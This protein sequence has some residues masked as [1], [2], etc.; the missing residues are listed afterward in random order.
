MID[1]AG[2]VASDRGYRPDAAARRRLLDERVVG[3]GPRTTRP[4]GL[5]PPVHPGRV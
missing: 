2:G 4:V 3:S 5:R 1:D